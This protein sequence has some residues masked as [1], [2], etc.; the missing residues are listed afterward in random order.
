MQSSSQILNSVLCDQTEALLADLAREI[1]R[2]RP[3]K[4]RMGNLCANLADTR[5][6]PEHMAY[7]V[8]TMIARARD[9]G[10]R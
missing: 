3:S 10:A 4:R 8:E 9:L 6:L 5:G 2:K 1:E 7:R